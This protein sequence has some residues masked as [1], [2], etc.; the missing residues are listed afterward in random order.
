MIE[1]NIV[2]KY[3]PE[4]F[5]YL[6]EST[7]WTMRS[8]RPIYGW[9]GKNG[10]VK[11][12][13]ELQKVADVRREMK[14]KGENMHWAPDAHLL[15]GYA[16]V[17]NTRSWVGYERR[18]W[19]LRSYDRDVCPD[20]N[21]AKGHPCEAVDPLSIAI[22]RQSKRGASDSSLRELEKVYSISPMW[23]RN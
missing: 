2:W 15:V 4:Q 12:L 7:Y 23:I 8:K 9:S 11:T 17:M 22:N 14:S 19:W 13:E 3:R 18:Y 21:Y 16:E 6:R 5:S 1:V 20:G 10:W